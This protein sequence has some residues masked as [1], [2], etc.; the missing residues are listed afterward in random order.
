MTD[1]NRGYVS[2]AGGKWHRA[3]VDKPTFIHDEQTA[4]GLTVRPL[5]VSW[6]GERPS[7]AHPTSFCKHCERQTQRPLLTGLSCLPGQQDLF[8]TDGGR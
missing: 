4:C 1:D 2:V 6:D 8:T 3:V 7:Y 5:N